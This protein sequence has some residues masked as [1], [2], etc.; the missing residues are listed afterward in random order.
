MTTTAIAALLEV[1]VAVVAAASI[2][3]LLVKRYPTAALAIVTVAAVVW[4]IHYHL[5][6]TCLTMTILLLMIIVEIVLTVLPAASV[7]PTASP[8]N[9]AVLV[10]VTTTVATAS[11]TMHLLLV[12][13]VVEVWIKGSLVSH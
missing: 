13:A 9:R 8:V 12:I 5:P 11:S 7:I 6:V 1:T 10:S 2:K 3:H 4:I